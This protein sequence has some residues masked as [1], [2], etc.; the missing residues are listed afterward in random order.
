MNNILD[1]VNTRLISPE[2][3]ACGKSLFD[4]FMAKEIT[5]DVLEE[6]LANMN[7]DCLTI[8][9]LGYKP[10]PT[11][12]AEYID[13]MSLEKYKQKELRREFYKSTKVQEYLD[14]KNKIIN[15]NKSRVY[16]LVKHI[17]IFKRKNDVESYKK[18]R[19]LLNH[20]RARWQVDDYINS[21]NWGKE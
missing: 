16:Y 7:K 18:C 6:S 5:R 11:A 12:P 2:K 17:Y 10:L 8:E 21:Q 20:H 9:E 19:F 15:E 13:F 4:A 1:I 3:V 14:S